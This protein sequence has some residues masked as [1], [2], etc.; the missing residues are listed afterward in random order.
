MGR[1]ISEHGIIGKIFGAKIYLVTPSVT[2]T[3]WERVEGA[4]MAQNGNFE[5]LL[6]TLIFYAKLLKF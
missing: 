3:S 2:R 5:R 4:K 1:R 6:K